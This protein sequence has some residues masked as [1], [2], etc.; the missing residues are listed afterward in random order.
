MLDAYAFGDGAAHLPPTARGVLGPLSATG[1]NQMRQRLRTI[2][3][4]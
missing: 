2:L 4:S 3:Q 1:R